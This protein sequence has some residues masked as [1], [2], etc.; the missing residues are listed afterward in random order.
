MPGL[1]LLQEKC[2]LLFSRTMVN[3]GI[4][5]L[6]LISM[7]TI[8]SVFLFSRKLLS[9]SK[10][11]LA[12]DKLLKLFFEFMPSLMIVS[13]NLLL[14]LLFSFLVTFEH[15]SPIVVVRIS[16]MRTVFLRLSSLGVLGAS[17]YTLVSCD[18]GRTDQ[19]TCNGDGTL[20]WETYVGQQFYKLA[21]TNALTGI[22]VTFFINFPRAL[23]ARQFEN[24]RFFRFIGE[25]QFELPNHVLDVVY[26]QTLC[27]IGSFYAPLLPGLATIHCFLTFY[28][29]K[30]ACLVNSKPPSQVGINY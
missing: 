3:V 27:W 30:F 5:I 17:I 20:C 7:L 11:D 21:V 13:L 2:R 12:D 26:S 14:P 22:A 6:L 28:V 1:L 18:D 4:M 23:L 8:Y 24:Y 19:C 25:Q 10:E 15:Y 29:K 16:L 9:D